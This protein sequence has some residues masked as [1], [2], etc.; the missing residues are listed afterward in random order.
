MFS[1]R[2]LHHLLLSYKKYYNGAR[3]HLS[4]N[5]ECLLD[6]LVGVLERPDVLVAVDRL[7]AAQRLVLARARAEGERNHRDHDLCTIDLDA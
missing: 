1:E 2:H 6:R 4:H 3:T 7:Q 5:N